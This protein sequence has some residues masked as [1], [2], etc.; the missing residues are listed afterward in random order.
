MHS[1]E[2]AVTNEKR[3]RKADHKL[4]IEYI[5]WSEL[6]EDFNLKAGDLDYSEYNKLEI[7]LAN[8]IKIN[9]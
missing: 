8:Y 5:N 6:V 3:F 1:V 9:K 4:L 2:Q 7:I